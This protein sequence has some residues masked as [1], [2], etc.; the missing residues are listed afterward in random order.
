MFEGF[1]HKRIKTAGAE[2][3]LVQGGVGAPLLLLHG[4]PQTHAIWHKVASELAK[5]FTL[6]IPDLRG[7][8]SSSKPP[9]DAD[10]LPYSKRA[11]ALDMVEVMTALGLPQFSVAG[12]DRGGRGTDA[13]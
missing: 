3:A 10:H 5:R 9:T 1:E 12:H 7:Y 6:V 4:Y 2:I 11:M 8:G 13:L